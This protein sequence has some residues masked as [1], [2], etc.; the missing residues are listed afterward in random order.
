LRRRILPNN[1][2]MVKMGAAGTW[3][4]VGYIMKTGGDDLFLE[5]INCRL[6]A[7]VIQF[8]Y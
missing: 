6:L 1:F 5:I 7:G 3:I 8:M 2:R 4:R